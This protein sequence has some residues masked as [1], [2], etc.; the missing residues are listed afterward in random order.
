MES[1]RLY[2]SVAMRLRGIDIGYDHRHS[3]IS[4]G[5]YADLLESDIMFDIKRTEMTAQ[6]A[7]MAHPDVDIEKSS[8]NVRLLYY[9]VLST[10]GYINGGKTSTDV[11][12][13]E[14][15]AAVNRFLDIRKRMLKDHQEAPKVETLEIKRAD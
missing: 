4:K 8:D 7:T 14:R 2:L 10:V 12:N 6:C 5:I 3:G 11:V 1:R 9:N 13:E 15:T